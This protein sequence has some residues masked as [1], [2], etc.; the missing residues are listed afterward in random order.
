MEFPFCEQGIVLSLQLI[1]HMSLG[2]EKAQLA[3]R[4]KF[5]ISLTRLTPEV[6]KEEDGQAVSI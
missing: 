3:Q 6:A 5:I 2:G 1:R 4:A